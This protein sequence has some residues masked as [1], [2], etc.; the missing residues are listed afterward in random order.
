MGGFRAAGLRARG[1]YNEEEAGTVR[2]VFEL[3][4]ELGNVRHVKQAADALGLTT[5]VRRRGVGESEDKAEGPRRTM[6]PHRSGQVA[7][8]RCRGLHLQAAGQ[9]ALCRLHC[10]QGPRGAA[11]GH[12]RPGHVEAVQQMLTA[13]RGRKRCIPT[14]RTEL[15]PLMGKLFD[16][17]GRP[18]TPSHAVK[19]GRR[20]RYYVSRHLVNGT[21]GRAPP[22]AAGDSRHGRSS[23]SPL[24]PSLH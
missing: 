6:H 1:S 3:Y 16:S 12:H 11:S 4:L 9:S 21:V 7:G 23:G 24:M 22:I 15:S 8:V 2:K 13:N 10:P 14:R 5:K 20:Y 18:L 17:D 19:S